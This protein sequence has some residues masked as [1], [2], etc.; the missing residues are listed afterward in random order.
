MGQ[1]AAVPCRPRLVSRSRLLVVDDHAH[2]R[3]MLLMLLEAFGHDAHGAADATA[4]RAAV[5]AGGVALALVD[6]R[7]GDEDGLALATALREAHPGLKV[8][9]MT[10]VSFDA[11]L[12]RAAASLGIPLLPKPFDPPALRTL[13]DGLLAEAA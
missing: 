12:D 5:A 11:G 1:R 10:G 6:H 9:L 3:E 2:V 4:A 8:V 7:L 13:I